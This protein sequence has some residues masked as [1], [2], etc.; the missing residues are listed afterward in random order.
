MRISFLIFFLTVSFIF[1]KEFK[2]QSHKANFI[3]PFSYNV[4]NSEREKETE[5]SFQLSV[6]KHLYNFTPDS[7]LYFG[8][9]QR[10]F[11]ELYDKENSSPF[12][13]T[14][15][16]PEFFVDTPLE[17]NRYGLKNFY[18]GFEHE[19]NG[20]GIEKSRS[21][22]RS[23]I[24]GFF[25]KGSFKGDIKIWQRISE[26]I[27]KDVN[28]TS[29]DDN[30]LIAKYY[31]NSEMNFSYDVDE[32]NR[33]S[34]FIRNIESVFEKEQF[35]SK[36]LGYSRRIDEDL[37]IFVKYFSGYG[38]SLIDYDVYIEKFSIGFQVY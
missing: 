33:L 9:T 38:E 10:S 15:Y 12:R 8:Y 31:G 13:E 1:A 16:N 14:N 35:I 7:R 18:I 36:E 5:V 20:Q 30:P 11:W 21:W 32:K 24:T 17:E 34:L 37:E 28:D 19:S 25:E 23:Y 27:K 3:A 26:E 4:K 6:K 29:G 2:L 22:N